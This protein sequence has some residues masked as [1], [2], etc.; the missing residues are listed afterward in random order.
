M[1]YF[2]AFQTEMLLGQSTTNTD[3]VHEKTGLKAIFQL[4]KEIKNTDKLA[5]PIAFQKAYISLSVAYLASNKFDSALNTGWKSLHIAKTQQTIDESSVFKQLGNIYTKLY[6]SDS[7]LFYFEKYYRNLDLSEF[8]ERLFALQK[9]SILHTENGSLS[10]GLD[11]CIIGIRVAEKEDDK[12]FIAIFNNRIGTIYSKQNSYNKAIEYFQKAL[13]SYEGLDYELGIA[14]SYA[15]IGSA[16]FG[17]RKFEEASSYFTKAKNIYFQLNQ[18]EGIAEMV[19]QLGLIEY[20]KNNLPSAIKLQ[21]EALTLRFDNKN[22]RDLPK[23]YV[24]LANSYLKLK[25]YDDALNLTREG[26][27]ITRRT[28]ADV[29]LASLYKQ[30][31]LIYKDLNYKDS[32]LFY[33]EKF[34]DLKDS[35]DRLENDEM[36]IRLQNAFDTE[37]R[38]IELSEVRRENELN[39]ERL[40]NYKELDEKDYYLKILLSSIIFILLVVAALFFSRYRIKSI[41]NKEISRKVKE[42]ELLLKELHHR[43]KNNLQFISSLLAIK[44]QKINDVDAKQMLQESLQKVRAMSI[45]HNKLNLNTNDDPNLN[46]KT[47]IDG[48]TNSLVLSLGLDSEQLQVAYRWRKAQFDID[49]FNSL[50][51]VINEMITNSFKHCDADNLNIKI[52]FYENGKLKMIRYSDNGPG[53]DSNYFS[54]KKQMGI[55]LMRLLVEDIGG[56]L[57]YHEPKED[58]HG[59]RISI[60]IK[61]NGKHG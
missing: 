44:A 21:Q 10:K 49:S 55:T 27:G 8:S 43:V 60:N 26:I 39:E 38:E 58:E 41:A 15:N 7:A 32:A 5:D 59:I 14:R 54:D 25:R 50:G 16:Y 35:I 22:Y 2:L 33:H 51:L 31:Y 19:D 28:G 23:S 30:F 11:Y 36:I 6:L 12:K 57:K 17:Q 4:K 47:F 9:L 13:N 20:R 29:Q 48:L 40:K 46:F 53:L 52:G 1:V 61:K 56:T 37:R 18:A 34:L 45:V 3:T 24:A 42:N